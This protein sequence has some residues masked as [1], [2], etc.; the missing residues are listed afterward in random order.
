MSGPAVRIILESVFHI[1]ILYSLKYLFFE[2]AVENKYVSFVQTLLRLLK[3][4]M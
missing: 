1:H 2:G 3:A 4:V